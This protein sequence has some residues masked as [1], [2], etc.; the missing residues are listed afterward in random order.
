MLCVVR[1]CVSFLFINIYFLFRY[2]SV[3][4]VYVFCFSCCWNRVRSSSFISLL[5]FNYKFSSVE[6]VWVWPV[7]HFFLFR[8]CFFIYLFRSMCICIAK[9]MHPHIILVHILIIQID[10]F[11]YCGWITVWQKETKSLY[12]LLL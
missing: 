6:C 8:C 12:F 3:F 10:L 11:S 7:W 9:S 5:Y 2:S 1:L 4:C